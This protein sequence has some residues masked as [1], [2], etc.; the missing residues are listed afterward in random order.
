MKFTNYECNKY[1]RSVKRSYIIHTLSDQKHTKCGNNV[2][3]TT[4]CI[5][6]VSP[7]RCI[8]TYALWF[9]SRPTEGS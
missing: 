3:L 8:F 2:I 5:T 4:N 1:Y 6:P 7:F 9:W